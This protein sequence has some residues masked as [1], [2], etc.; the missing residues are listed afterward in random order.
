MKEIQMPGMGKTLVGLGLLLVAVG[1]LFWAGERIFGRSGGFLP[2]DLVMRKGTFTFAF[3][4]VTCIVLSILLSLLL[5]VFL[6]FMG[7]SR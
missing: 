7:G 6:R 3:P 4:I 1:G 2:G 5:N